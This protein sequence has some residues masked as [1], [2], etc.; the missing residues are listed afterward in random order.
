ME[1]FA[2]SAR[3]ARQAVGDADG[4]A[5]EMCE[6]GIDGS[7]GS[8]TGADDYGGFLRADGR[9]RPETLEDADPVGVEPYQ[10]PVWERQALLQVFSVVA[11]P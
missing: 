2:A 6:Q 7:P 1:Y 9:R 5:I 3:R 8:T 10:L 4:L 11:K